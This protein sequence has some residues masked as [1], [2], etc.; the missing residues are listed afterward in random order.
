MTEE[1]VA[2]AEEATGACVQELNLVGPD[3]D[4]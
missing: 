4:E 1:V 2:E 3:Y